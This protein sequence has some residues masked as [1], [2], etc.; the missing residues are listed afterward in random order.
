M[1][2]KLLVTRPEHD[3]TTT[4]LSH[5]AKLVIK[6]A[7]ERGVPV[8]DFKAGTVK[9]ETI[10]KFIEKQKPKLIFFNGHGA[11]IVLRE[12]KERL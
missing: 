6:Y 7:E 9:K 11:K 1:S 10:N 12:K 8:T 2:K 4:Y 5:Y 3:D